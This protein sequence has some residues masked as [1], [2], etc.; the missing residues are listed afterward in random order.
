TSLLLG[1]HSLKWGVDFRQVKSLIAP[2]PI[3]PYAVFTS[4]QHLLNGAP[5]TPY[6]FHFNHA[7]PIFRQFAAY[8][9]D[10]WQVARNVHLSYGVR[11]EINPPPTEQ[12][13]QDAFTLLGDIN[14]PA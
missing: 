1:S 7:T 4:A 11:W 8:L 13:G 10:E 6:V 14:A 3:E 5:S 9:Q 12:H 2:T